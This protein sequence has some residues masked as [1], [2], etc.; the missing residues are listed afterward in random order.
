ML[1]PY[2]NQLGMGFYGLAT[3]PGSLPRNRFDLTPYYDAGC[4]LL[5]SYSAPRDLGLD[6]SNK[7]KDDYARCLAPVGGSVFGGL[8]DQVRFA[9]EVE[10]WMQLYPNEIGFFYLPEEMRIW[11]PAEKEA[12]KWMVDYIDQHTPYR[13]M[14]YLP[15]H[16]THELLEQYAA[17][18]S[19]VPIL[20]CYRYEHNHPQ[21]WLT[22]RIHFATCLWNS[23]YVALE[24]F[25]KPLV[26]GDAAGDF[27]AAV[28]AGAQ[29]VM[30]FSDAYR[31]INPQ[32]HEAYLEC[33][34]FFHDTPE[35]YQAIAC[36]IN[37]SHNIIWWEPEETFMQAYVLDNDLWFFI[38]EKCVRDY[39]GTTVSIAVDNV[40]MPE[41]LFIGNNDSVEISRRDGHYD[42]RFLCIDDPLHYNHIHD[43]MH[44]YRVQCRI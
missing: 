15:G 23:V 42:I 21:E 13:A 10:D 9:S 33:V 6:L 22:D 39:L 8:S 27:F 2:G 19:L 3:K 24:L 28:R 18:P 32:A 4:N 1:Q 37:V 35:A 5:H 31:N 25:K 43:T 20:G 30:V 16:Y 34:Q 26:P 44:I 38:Q 12:L 36:G 40:C 11:K 17:F 14:L 7:N 41:S 29:G